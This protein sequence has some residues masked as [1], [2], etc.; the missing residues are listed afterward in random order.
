MKTLKFEF[1]IQC[2]VYCAINTHHMLNIE[3][4]AIARVYCSTMKIAN[5]N[6][7][8]NFCQ[9]QS[10]VGKLRTDLKQG[11]ADLS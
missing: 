10:V 11:K 4:L 3:K 7:I 1:Q 2:C 5:F 6:N 8:K 9:T